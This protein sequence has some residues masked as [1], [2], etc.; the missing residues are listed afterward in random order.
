L[1]ENGLTLKSVRANHGAL[2][3]RSKL[4]Q[5]KRRLLTA[6]ALASVCVV[7]A[8]A[9]PAR[10]AP[11]SEGEVV[12]IPSDS[13][14]LKGVLFRP[15]TN[16]LAPAVVFHHGGGGCGPATGAGPRIVGNRFAERG[17]ALLW[18]YRRGVGLSAGE[19][20]CASQEIA[21]VRA[22]KGEDAAMAVQL[23]R[24]ITDELDDA[25]AGLAALRALPDIDT[26]RIVVGGASRGGQLAILSAERDSRVRAV[27]NFV[28][29][30]AAWGRSAGIRQRLVSAVGALKMPIYLGYAEDDN[31]EPG[32]VLAAELA[33]LGK[34]YQLDIYPT[35]G[36][37]FIFAAD[38][39]GTTDV[40]RFLSQHVPR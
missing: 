11:P 8:V 7:A 20:D 17:Y 26:T 31:A 29:G 25:L 13:L 35:G 10:Q 32:R 15:K 40:F 38:H 18:V 23:R 16:A 4:S 30:A 27:L 37:G 19:G 14:R 3:L 22:E 34:T 9:R 39:P 33:R 5:M 36:H 12:T 1:L 24:L 2:R 21:R 28:G 6:A